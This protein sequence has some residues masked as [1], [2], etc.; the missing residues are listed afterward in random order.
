MTHTA[1]ELHPKLRLARTRS[2]RGI[3][4]SRHPRC[5]RGAL[6]LSYRTLF[7]YCVLS[8]GIAPASSRLQGECS[9]NVSYKSICESSI[10]GAALTFRLTIRVNGAEGHA[11]LELALFLGGSQTPHHIGMYPMNRLSLS[12]LSYTIR[13][14]LRDS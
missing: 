14:T 10:L 12:S 7:S 4:K 3:S 2:F 11:R 1:T 13:R 6:P 5:K 8:T 9:A